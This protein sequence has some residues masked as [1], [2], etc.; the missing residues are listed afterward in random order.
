VNV[1]LKSKTKYTLFLKMT[2]DDPSLF[3]NLPPYMR[4]RL[5]MAASI[6][7]RN[8][9]LKDWTYGHEKL[10]GIVLWNYEYNKEISFKY[11]RLF[12]RHAYGRSHNYILLKK[13]IEK[14]IL[15]KDG[16]G[17][18]SFDEKYYSLITQLSGL[19]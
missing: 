19:I 10:L 15:V 3:Q 6:I 18:Y 9:D 11:S 17:F 7:F 14:K 1:L 5:M 4:T 12:K 8:S 16:N 13:I 2:L